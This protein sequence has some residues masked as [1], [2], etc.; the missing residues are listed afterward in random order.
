MR[1]TAKH[2]MFL[3]MV[4]L[5]LCAL[6]ALGETGSGESQDFTV[7]TI[8]EPATLVAAAVLA[9]CAMRRRPAL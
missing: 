8:P 7:N 3:F 5:V 4:G 6:Q 1:S 9:F 2:L